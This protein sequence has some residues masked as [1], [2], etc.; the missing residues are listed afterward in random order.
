MIRREKEGKVPR[1][2]PEDPLSSQ[3][4]GGQI[5][6]EEITSVESTAL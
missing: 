6:V 1:K 2:S 5:R 3:K 4:Q